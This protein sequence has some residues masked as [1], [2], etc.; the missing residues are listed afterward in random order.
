METKPR[1]LRFFGVSAALHAAAIAAGIAFVTIGERD[2]ATLEPTVEVTLVNPPGEPA[3][4]VSVSSPATVPPLSGESPPEAPAITPFAPI[5]APKPVERVG[6]VSTEGWFDQSADVQPRIDETGAGLGGAVGDAASGD[7][8]ALS[9]GGPAA[10]GGG[11]DSVTVWS[12]LDKHKR[13]PPAAVRR[14]LEGEVTLHLALDEIG[15]VRE[16]RIAKSS[17]H[18]MLD[19]EVIHMVEKAAPFPIVTR[20]ARE[21]RFVIVFYLEDP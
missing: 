12:W 20:A 2:R 4:P 14:H 18:R 7:A 8:T 17:G 3:Q 9:R 19:D 5:D 11:E 13:Y 6:D 1:L 15:G 10:R 21:Y 16:A